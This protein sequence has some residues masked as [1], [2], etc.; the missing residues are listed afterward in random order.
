MVKLGFE[1]SV[2][3]LKHGIILPPEIKNQEVREEEEEEVSD[4]RH[5]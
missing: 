3:A 2:Q 5:S 4:R 1:L